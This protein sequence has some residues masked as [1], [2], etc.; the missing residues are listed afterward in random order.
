MLYP[1]VAAPAAV[2]VFALNHRQTD[3]E[4]EIAT[5]FFS[6][7]E[8]EEGDGHVR[9]ACGDRRVQSSNPFKVLQHSEM[10]RMNV[11]CISIIQCLCLLYSKPTDSNRL[12]K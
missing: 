1:A 9:D 4:R 5:H 11:H 10:L 6:T 2:T 7:T 3:R 12:L 8:S